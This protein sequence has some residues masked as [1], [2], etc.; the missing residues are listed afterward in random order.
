M[1]KTPAA[2][3]TMEDLRVEIDRIDRALVMLLAER[4]GFI[5]RA[6]E[7]KQ[8]IGLPARIP[9]RVEEVVGNVR[10]AAVQGFDPDQAEALWRALIEWSIRREELAL[11]TGKTTE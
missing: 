6:A 10:R 5:D 2:C 4:T 3:R 9:A 7:I 1:S 8:G 11:E